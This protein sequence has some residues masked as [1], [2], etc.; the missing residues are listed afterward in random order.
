MKTVKNY[1]FVLMLVLAGLSV[2]A[3]KPKNTNFLMVK[4]FQ[5]GKSM[6]LKNGM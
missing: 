5:V 4:T 2:E 1:L 6:V 3:Q